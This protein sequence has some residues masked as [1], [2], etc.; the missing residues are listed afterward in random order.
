MPVVKSKCKEV[1]SSVEEERRRPVEE[2]T[3]PVE[4]NTKPTEEVK[5]EEVKSPLITKELPT[6]LYPC[7]GTLSKMKYRISINFLNAV[8]SSTIIDQTGCAILLVCKNTNSLYYFPKNWRLDQMD[9][10]L[11]EYDKVYVDEFDYEAFSKEMVY[12]PT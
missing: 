1:L 4:E 5:K 7:V 9:Y 11:V 6:Y 10:H 3:K 2:N 8:N 12:A